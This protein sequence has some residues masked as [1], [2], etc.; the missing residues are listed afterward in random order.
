MKELEL[1][2]EEVPH[3]QGLPLVIMAM[4][5]GPINVIGFNYLDKVEFDRFD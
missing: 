5:L 3:Q 2:Q 1:V 4:E